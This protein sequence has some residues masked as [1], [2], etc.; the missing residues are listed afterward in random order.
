MEQQ[1]YEADVHQA[2]RRDMMKEYRNFLDAQK[3]GNATLKEQMLDPPEVSNNFA[4]RRMMM[5]QMLP[6]PS[7]QQQQNFG[8]GNNSSSMNQIL[9]A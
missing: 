5:N 3:F 4:S 7:R 8:A 2:A 1:K 9:A 6:P